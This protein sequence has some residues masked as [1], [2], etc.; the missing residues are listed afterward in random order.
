MQSRSGNGRASQRRHDNQHMIRPQSSCLFI[1]LRL[2]VHVN[3]IPEYLDLFAAWKVTLEIARAHLIRPSPHSPGSRKIRPRRCVCVCW[4][5]QLGVVVVV[6]GRR[7]F[8]F[9]LF[10]LRFSSSFSSLVDVL[11]CVC[12][13]VYCRSRA[14]SL[15]STL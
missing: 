6:I 11:S 8:P 14:G 3:V 7:T 5:C 13:C 12:V 15:L 1:S 4:S 9:V 2:L 10:F